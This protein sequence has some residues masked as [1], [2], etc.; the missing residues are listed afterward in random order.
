MKQH[1]LKTDKEVFQASWDKKKTYE[2]RFDDRNFQSGDELLIVETLYTG[3]E[4]KNGRPLIYTGRG[5]QQLVT[6]KLKN[7]YGLVPGWCILSVFQF[8]SRTDYEPSNNIQ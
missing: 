8:A 1:I 3:E 7:M 2:I 4:M 5:I 6:H